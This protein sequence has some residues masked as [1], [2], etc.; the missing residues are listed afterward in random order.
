MRYVLT[1]KE[2][3]TATGEIAY[4]PKARLVVIGLLGS[5]QRVH[6]CCCNDAL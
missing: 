5:R 1:W 4:K 6:R 3:R 2:Y